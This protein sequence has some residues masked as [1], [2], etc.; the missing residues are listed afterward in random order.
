VS[1]CFT[2]IWLI[3]GSNAIYLVSYKLSYVDMK[4]LGV[5]SICFGVD[6]DVVLC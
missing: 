3:A 1:T 6:D 2:H 4:G 5:D